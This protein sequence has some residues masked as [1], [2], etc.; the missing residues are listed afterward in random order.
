MK[1]YNQ[2]IK[3]YNN[4]WSPSADELPPI[5]KRDEYLDSV[6]SLYEEIHDSQ[7]SNPKIS[8]DTIK[9]DIV[10]HLKKFT[11]E[12]NL[13]ITKAHDAVKVYNVFLYSKYHDGEKEERFKFNISSNNIISDNS[14]R[15]S[16][17]SKIKIIYEVPLDNNFNFKELL[18]DYCQSRPDQTSKYIDI[19]QKIFPD[20]DLDYLKKQVD[21]S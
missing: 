2:Y 11:N 9:N 21:W 18:K 16:D 10:K 3:E 8:F 15:T 13:I 20:L 12:Y 1:T 19:I 6:H 4:M 5:P 17:L 14:Y 7:E